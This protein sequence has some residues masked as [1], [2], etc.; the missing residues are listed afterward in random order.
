MGSSKKSGS[1]KSPAQPTPKGGP[2]VTPYGQASPFNPQ[3]TS[4]LPTDGSSAMLND[5]SRLE[6]GDP[7]PLLAQQNQ[8]EAEAKAKATAGVG[9]PSAYSQ[10]MQFS[11][12]GM[13][14][15][16]GDNPFSR[17]ANLPSPGPDASPEDKELHKNAMQRAVLAT[18]LGGR[19]KGA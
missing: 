10:Y 4:F 9:Q 6:G 18:F 2:A 11:N 8:A 13:G 1:S 19:V 3:Y 7:T 14:G 17:I 16:R 12:N 5:P 15:G